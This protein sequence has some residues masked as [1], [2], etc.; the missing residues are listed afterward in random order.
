MVH[1]VFSIGVVV[2]RRRLNSP[3]ATHAWLPVAALPAV[4]ETAPW[5]RLGGGNAADAFYAGSAEITLYAQATSHYR[6]NLMSVRP[7]LWI[8]LRPVGH[9]I[10]LVSATADPYEGEALAES[11]GDIVEP[12]PMPTSIQARVQSFSHAFHVERE[13]VKRKRNRADP[14]IMARRQSRPPNQVHEE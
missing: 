3:W 14:E 8:V 11:I 12:V 9:E 13:F 4:P 7:S 6:D 2:A 1:D 5:T 10:Q